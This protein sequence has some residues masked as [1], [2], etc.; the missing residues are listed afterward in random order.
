MKTIIM[1][2]QEGEESGRGGGEG[3]GEGGKLA[4]FYRSTLYFP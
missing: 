4:P 2:R 3:E 1:M